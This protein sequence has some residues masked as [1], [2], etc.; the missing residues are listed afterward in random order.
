MNKLTKY[1]SCANSFRQFIDSY[2]EKDKHFVNK[3]VSRL[4]KVNPFDVTLRDG[5]QG[6][7]KDEQLT[8]KTIDK[9]KLYYQIKEKYNPKNI[10]IGSVVSSKLFPIFKD[11]SVLYDY[12]ESDRKNESN[13]NNFI[14]FPNEKQ[15]DENI[16][17]F[18][19]LQCFSFI[20]SVSESFQQKNTR[21]SLDN[22]FQQLNNM[23]QK[24]N[25]RNRNNR[26]KLYVS[27]I[28]ECPIEGK[29][30]NNIVI[31]KILKYQELKP[32]ILCLS[33]TCGTL[34]EEDLNYIMVNLKR[35]ETT[36]TNLSLHLHVKPGRE[37]EVEKIIHS[38]L[39]F[40]ITNF[41]VSALGSGG[42]SVTMNKSELAP[43]L[44]Y[45]LYY[46]SLYT[47]LLKE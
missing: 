14:L 36:S 41:D 25:N 10:E 38:A 8:I 42:C 19:G 15:F 22:T 37:S 7:S 30:N 34:T 3:Y 39:D 2:G 24:V 43:N 45:E 29:I 46:K 31:E 47:Y 4:L 35:D 16:N 44:S 13:I 33:D 21:M 32:D 20:T 28:N 6:L 12:I 40:G 17:K 23:I 5:L 27:C 11:S 1:P 9:V 26:I 18:I